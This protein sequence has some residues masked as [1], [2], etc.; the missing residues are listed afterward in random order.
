[1]TGVRM[2]LALVR[3]RVRARSLVGGGV[4]PTVFSAALTTLF[5]AFMSVVPELWYHREMLPV[6]ALSMG[7]L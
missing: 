4:T 3:R 1:M 6:S 5:R 2:L 7:P